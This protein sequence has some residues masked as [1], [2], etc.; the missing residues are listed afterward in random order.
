FAEQLVHVPSPTSATQIEIDKLRTELEK[1]AFPLRDQAYKFFET[2]HRRSSE[3]VTLSVW[4]RRSYN[5]MS[6]LNSEKYPEVL[7]KVSDAE[8]MSHKLDN[9]KSVA[10]LAE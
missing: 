10:E 2:A 4:T 8:Y 6:D 7:E 1:V 5:K 3:V 9:T